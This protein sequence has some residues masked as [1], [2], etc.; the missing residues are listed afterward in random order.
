MSI[1]LINSLRS[2]KEFYEHAYSANYLQ[3][4]LHALVYG[5]NTRHKLYQADYSEEEWA[6]IQHLTKSATK[7]P[8]ICDSAMAILVGPTDLPDDL[9]R[10]ALR[11]AC[12]QLRHPERNNFRVN[13]KLFEESIRLLE[14]WILSQE[15]SPK[16][17]LSKAEFSV[18]E[19]WSSCA[20]KP[21]Y[22][23]IASALH[24]GKSTVTTA[25][26]ELKLLGLIPQD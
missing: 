24:M 12:E 20:A 16:R 14:L 22:D 19:Y 17:K 11:K 13:R 5:D 2:I 23:D 8:E 4:A 25:I 21:S 1:P 7:I 10:K 6:E 15:N 9:D 3:L 18:L 26:N